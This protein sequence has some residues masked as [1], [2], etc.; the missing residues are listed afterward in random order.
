[1]FIFFAI[2]AGLV[3]LLISALVIHGVN[4]LFKI[5]GATFPKAL[6]ISFPLFLLTVVNGSFL[7]PLLSWI[8][9]IASIAVLFA[10]YK[11][12]FN[13]SFVKFA[14]VSATYVAI[15][16]AATLLVVI[17][18][19]LYAITAFA[20]SGNSMAPTFEAGDFVLVGK[21]SKSFDVGDYVIAEI[22]CTNFQPCY[23]AR[24]ITEV[25][26]DRYT[27]ATET[28]LAYSINKDALVGKVIL[29]LGQGW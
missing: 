2:V 17:P 12:L 26:G 21:I 18:V 1:M 28:G 24:K 23:V 29:N 22:P 25:S 15:S 19:R 13:V 9:I 7:Y 3:G 8:A 4:R 11:K 14:G 5:D 16:V 10:V 6:G 27:I 20:I